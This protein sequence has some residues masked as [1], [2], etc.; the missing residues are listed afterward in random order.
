MFHVSLCVFLLEFELFLTVLFLVLL[1]LG[2]GLGHFEGRESELSRRQNRF[3]FPV[4]LGCCRYHLLRRQR[5]LRV[6]VLCAFGV[7]VVMVVI[8]LV[9]VMQSRF[10]GAGVAW[11]WLAI[12]MR[13]VY[14]LLLNML[15]VMVVVMMT[16][17][18][19]LCFL[20]G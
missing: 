18:H 9:V 3:F 5:R 1:Y 15:W 14:S 2:L 10:F 11:L 16:E 8:M 6:R 19:F 12:L 4:Q 13:L 17:L 7:V 20:F